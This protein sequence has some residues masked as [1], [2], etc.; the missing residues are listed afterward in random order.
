MKGGGAT[1]TVEWG[2]ELH[3][4][5]LGPEHWRLIKSGKVLSVRGKGYDYEGEFFSDYWTF[6]GGVGGSLLVRYG[7]DGGVGYEGILNPSMV[8]ERD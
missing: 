5:A 6:S 1:I 7:E 8:E 3:S 4:I 2:Y